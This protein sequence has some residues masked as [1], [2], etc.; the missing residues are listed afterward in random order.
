MRRALLIT[1]I[2]CLSLFTLADNFSYGAYNADLT[3]EEARIQEEQA[4]KEPV[5]PSIFIWQLPEQ[6]VNDSENAE[7]NDDYADY[8]E[9]TDN[10]TAET[11][12]D[13]FI[14]DYYE[15][16]NGTLKGYLDYLEDSNAITLNTSDTT[17]SINLSKPQA[18]ASSRLNKS[19][20]KLPM[21]TFS[22]H[23]YERNSNIAY[24]IAPFDHSSE[25]FD[26]RL[27]YGTLS[28]GTSYN[29]SIDTSDLG[30][31]TSFYTKYENKYFS[32]KSSYDKN[33][34]VAYSE[35]IDKFTLTPEIKLNKYISIKDSVTSDITRNRTKNEI[36]LSIK[37]SKED[38]VRFEFGANQTY[39]ANSKLL[40]SQI[41]FSTMFRW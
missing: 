41:K 8:F 12:E 21:T 18:L 30:F 17:R 31:T 9:T 6:T 1:I 27:K 20:F 2:A 19:D 28:M 3:E 22:H 26:H 7:E 13:I 38:R 4:A 37:P 11:N 36:I 5:L 25:I 40:R 35:V 33:S 29:E 23:L 39:D 32:L 24:N 10:N 14:T 34:G 16:D 15:N